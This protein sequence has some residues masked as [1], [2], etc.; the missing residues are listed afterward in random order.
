MK[1]KP[2]IYA[3]GMT[4][5]AV[6]LSACTLGQP[7]PETM[8]EE[9]PVVLDETMGETA[10]A[11][12]MSIVETAAAAGQF[13]TLLELATI[14]GLA[15]VLSTES[16]TV[17]APTDAAFAKVPAE[18]LEALKADPEGLANVL[19]YHVI[20]GPVPAIQVA[21]LTT[22]DTLQGS[23]L[24]ITASEEGVMVNDATVLQ[25]DIVASNGLIHV[26]DT[27]LIPTE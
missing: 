3:L 25:T 27:V 22:V 15:D 14:A 9:V 12:E 7:A 16:V 6:T 23:P 2:M 11:V 20:A 8:V 1:I 13:N 26:I 21:S 24:A 4:V 18:T 19:K 10:P 17:F 5:F